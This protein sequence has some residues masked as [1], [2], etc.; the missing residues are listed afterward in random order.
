[1]R[2]N[3]LQ[4]Y[5]HGAPSIQAHAIDSEVCRESTCPKCGRVGMNYEPYLTQ[6]SYRPFAVCPGCGFQEEF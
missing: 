1:M 3:T 5:K 4:G 2:L 6:T